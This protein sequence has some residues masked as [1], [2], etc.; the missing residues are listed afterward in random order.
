MIKAVIFDIDDT[1]YS[2]TRGNV[3]G[4]KAVADYMEAHFGFTPERTAAATARAMA[5]VNERMGY[6][7]AAIHNRAIRYQVLLENEGLP[8]MPHAGNLDDVYWKAILDNVEIEPGVVDYIRSLKASGIRVGVGT[9][10]TVRIQ[11]D[12]L[13]R[14]GVAEM[15][16]FIVSSE[17]AGVEKPAPKFY[18][19]CVAK[20]GCE[21]GEIAFIGD[22]LKNDAIAACEAG[23]KGIWYCPS[24]KEVPEGC[25]VEVIRDFR[26]VVR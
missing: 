14:I 9:N 19:L 17:E 21:P 6:V 2:Y 22:N 13:E 11:Y 10:M 26:Q 7:C 23:M 16:D 3:L 15:I 4:L 24:G 8:V 5:V 20:A 18:D 12:K 25:P 1:L